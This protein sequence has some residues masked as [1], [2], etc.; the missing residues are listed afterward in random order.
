VHIVWIIYNDW[1][2]IANE[3]FGT[4]VPI[5]LCCMRFVT[6]SRP[7]V[8]SRGQLDSSGNLNDGL[9][10]VASGYFTMGAVL[11]RTV[12]SL[13]PVLITEMLMSLEMQL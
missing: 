2:A 1:I 9:I 8:Y 5:E 4:D 6:G 7:P 3:I 13:I 11:L 12:R 10:L